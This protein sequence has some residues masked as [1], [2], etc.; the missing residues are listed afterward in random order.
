M[1]E[2]FLNDI[3]AYEKDLRRKAYGFYK[4]NKAAIDDLVQETIVKALSNEDKFTKGTN[5]R[6]WL[7]TIQYHLFVNKHR[8]KKKFYEILEEHRP[9]LRDMTSADPVE[10]DPSGEMEMSSILDLLEDGLGDIFYEVLLLVDVKGLSYKE[11]ADKLD[12]P[13]GT[14]MSR[15]FRARRKARE[16]LLKHYDFGVL[17]EYLSESTLKTALD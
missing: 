17:S 16:A 5:L 7:I 10:T 4:G 6:G 8:R 11:A 12:V 1:N 3:L 13:Q 15:L 9:S 14:V 2:E